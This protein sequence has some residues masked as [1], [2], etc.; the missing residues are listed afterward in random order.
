MMNLEDRRQQKFGENI[1][2]GSPSKG[3]KVID[4]HHTLHQHDI[5]S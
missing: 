1:W 5:K 4:S 2:F 3:V